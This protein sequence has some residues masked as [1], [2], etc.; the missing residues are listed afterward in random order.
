ML[1]FSHCNPYE[2]RANVTVQTPAGGTPQAGGTSAPQDGGDGTQ[3]PQDGT[4]RQDTEPT[5]QQGGQPDTADLPE[6]V[7]EMLRNYRQENRSL[8]ERLRALEQS[9]P[10]GGQGGQPQDGSITREEFQRQ[11]QQ[12]QERL[13]QQGV[14]SEVAM[15]S[16][17]L[18]VVDAEAAYRLLDR[19]DLDFDD[20]GNPTNVEQAM[21]SLIRERPWLA[22]RQRGGDADGGAGNGQ[23]RRG[24]SMNDVLR[25]AAGKGNRPT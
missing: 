16:A 1:R 10:Q 18:G 22:N 21:K 14:R 12:W 23:Q 6:P 9:Q 8:R 19:D 11:E 15:V 2:A 25:A 24:V 4:N 5:G 13:R 20:K 7:Q 3:Q 17:K